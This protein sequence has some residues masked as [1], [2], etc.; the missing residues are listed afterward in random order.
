LSHHP[1]PGHLNANDIGRI[2]LRTAEPLA[3]DPYTTSRHTGSFLLID[4]T[5]GTT[6]A[7]GVMDTR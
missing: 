5:D 4:P 2:T 1:A 6:L 7:G 3:L